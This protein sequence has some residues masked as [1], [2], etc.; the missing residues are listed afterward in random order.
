M[1]VCSNNNCKRTHD[2]KLKTCPQCLESGRRSKKERRRLAQ[3]KVKKGFQM[4]KRCLNVKPNTDFE[5]KRHRRKKMTTL[6]QRCRCT[7]RK[8][9]KKT[10]TKVG[11]CREFWRNWKEEQKCVNCGISY[12]RLIEADHI[13]GPKICSV[14]TYSYWACNGGVDAMRKELEKCVPRCRICHTIKTLERH[15]LKR[16]KEGRKAKTTR[17]RRR[18]EINTIKLEIGKCDHCS[19]TVTPE[20]CCAFDFDHKDEEKKIICISNLAYKSKKFYEEHLHSEIA[21]CQLLCRNCHHLKTHYPEDEDS[22]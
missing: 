3:Q 10:S 20:S 5:S 6:C 12:H 16:Q 22:P 21:K 15:E 1:K 14:S 4:C 13:R 2:T 17:K 11:K 9:A 18:N 19:R 7:K 8:N